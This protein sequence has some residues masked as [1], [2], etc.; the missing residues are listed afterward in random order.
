MNSKMFLIVGGLI[1]VA[2]LYIFATT[3]TPIEPKSLKQ[4]GTECV[5]RQKD[6]YTAKLSGTQTILERRRSQNWSDMV[7]AC[8]DDSPSQLRKDIAAE[9]DR[10]LYN[11]IS[12]GGAGLGSLMFI[13]GLSLQRKEQG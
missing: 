7:T 11:G 9:E 2:S 12:M 5:E 3:L 1:L 4:Y 8:H 6:L 10:K 13:Y